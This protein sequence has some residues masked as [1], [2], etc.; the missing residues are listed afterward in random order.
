MISPELSFVRVAVNLPQSAGVFDYH[1]PDAFIGSVKIGS[2]VVVPF[3]EQK[4]QGIVL[5]LPESPA[6]PETREVIALLDK[7]QVLTPPQIQLAE[8]LA[9]QHLTPLPICLTAMLPPG[10]SKLADTA[11]NLEHLPLPDEPLSLMQQRILDHLSTRGELRGRQIDQHIPRREWRRPMQNLIQKGYVSSRPIL[12][13][14]T[15][16]PKTVKTVRLLASPEVLQAAQPVLGRGAAGER[17]QMIIDFLAHEAW[18][19]DVAWVYAHAPGANLA[20]LRH[21]AELELVRLGEN[22]VW[23]DPL[24]DLHYELS[25]APPLSAQQ[26]SVWEPIHAQLTQPD[27]SLPK[28]PIILQGV[29][30][31]GKT[32]I[33]LRAVEDA[34]KQ[35]KTVLVLTPEISLT[36]QTVR[37]FAGRFPG[38]VG[39][40]HSRLSAG[41]RYDT[42]RRARNGNLPIIVGARS[43]LFTPLPS[44]GL[45]IV[46]EFDD[47]SYY[48]RDPRFSYHAVQAALKL[49]ELTNATILL[50]SATPDISLRY[51]AEQRGWQILHMP[52]RI[53]AHRETINA[54]LREIGAVKQIN[55]LAHQGGQE[56]TTVNHLPPVHVIDMR[57][58][59]KQGNS[60][61]FSQALQEGLQQVLDRQ[62]QA[63][64]YLNRRG[65]ATYVF[66]R[67]C[68]WVVKCAD[69]DK[70]LVFHQGSHDL[71]CHTCSYHRNMPARCPQCG[72]KRIRQYGS[73]TE[74]V[75]QYVREM[76]PQARV[77]R[78]DHE[79]TREKN[80]H[81]II[82]SHFA[83][84]RA[85]ILIGTQMLSKGLD[86]PLVTLVGVV[87]ADVGLQ[88]PDFRANERVFQLLTQVA[89]RAGRSPLGGQVFLQTFDPEHYVI[90]HAA[91]HDVDGF[92]RAEMQYRLQMEYP[93]FTRLLRLETRDQNLN[94]VETRAYE[95]LALLQ[96][97]LAEGG[98]V[99]T[100]IIGPVPCYFEKT[101]GFYRWQI[102]LR[103]PDPAAVIRAHLPLHHWMI[104]VDPPSLL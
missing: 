99:A 48:Q 100:R 10:L 89:G 40:V 34:L 47:Q 41:E 3:G 4:V 46:D 33:Y 1:I 27:E 74:K 18:E 88:L 42:W 61:I 63:I 91:K 69:C 85:D 54:H 45:I 9:Y 64:L 13:A 94:I 68:G 65:S 84:H 35:K 58:E 30:G 2:L 52:Q 92:Y 29:T 98:H 104:E 96:D 43:A 70:P 53:V 101:S 87:L 20:D 37:R 32:E 50:G 76:F 17:R 56:T 51:R 81:E 72:S 93:P 102:I 14:P 60:T 21:L 103:G 8:W 7:E 12:P 24:D 82:F 36:P 44:L 25:F 57:E 97:W 6:V 28:K 16:H 62:E 49:A 67:E 71:R 95:M 75:E 38:K 73:G 39:L 59:L 86:L 5:E 90:R 26:Q 78:Y 79:S 80:A 77:L 83:N 55:I 11:F 31:S 19:V 15:I 22:E 66:C 23:R